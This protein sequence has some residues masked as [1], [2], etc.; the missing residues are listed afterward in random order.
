MPPVELAVEL[1]QRLR[2]C[3]S[4]SCWKW[5]AIKGG[6]YKPVT[7]MKAIWSMPLSFA[8]GSLFKKYAAMFAA[9][10]GLA[11]LVNG[12]ANIWSIWEENRSYLARL[13]AE[14]ASAA[15]SRISQFIKD[16][17]PQLGWTTHF[18]WL[19]YGIEQHRLDGQRL[20]RQ[21]PAIT[22][23]TLLDPQGRE[24]LRLSRQ[25]EDRVG[26]NVDYSTQDSYQTAIAGKIYY[27][28]VYFQ[29]QTEPYVTLAMGGAR[30]EAG[31]SIAEVNLQYIWDVVNQIRVGV[32]GRAYVVGP[33][34]QLIAHPDISRVLRNTNV[35]SL[36]QVAAARGAGPGAPLSSMSALDLD[37]NPV[38]TTS[39]V[40]E[41]MQW[42]VF[43]EL[44]ESEANAPLYRALSRWLVLTL[45]G[46]ALALIPALLL[47]R[48]MVVPIRSLAAGAEQ[49]GAGSL[50]H[51]IA[52]KSGDELESLSEQFN[53]MARRLQSSYEDLER[54][55]DER[56]RRLQDAD[57]AK[58]RF[59]AVASHDL[60]QPL[61][62]LNLFAAQLETTTDLAERQALV[63]N[64]TSSIDSMNKLFNEL[65][66]I[67]RLD[68]GALTPRISAFP[69]ADILSEIETTF[70][71]AARE[72]GLRFRV[73]KSS[74][75]VESDPIL[76]GRI[77]LNLVSN[78]VRYTWTG[79]VVVGCRRTRTGLRIDVCD[80]GPGIPEDQ[81]GTI[82]GEFYRIQ[83]AGQ[84][85]GEGLGLGLAIV[86]R[87]C[88]L[89]GHALDLTSIEGKG[90]RFSLSAPI[91][92]ARER[93]VSDVLLP[94]NDVLR[95]KLVVVIDDAPLVREGTRGLL[96]SWGCRVVVAE[97]GAEAIA[98]LAGAEP[99]LIISDLHLPDG[100]TGVEAIA[101]LRLRPGFDVPA[102]LISG[103]ISA[104]QIGTVDRTPYPLLHK[105]L[106]PMAL[107]A[108][109]TAMLQPSQMRRRR[110]FSEVDSE[111]PSRTPS[112][113]ALPPFGC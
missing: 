14:Q 113:Q 1:G 59:L 73:V 82:F 2:P 72:K 103:D 78:A 36:P 105:P 35:S 97:S 9:V 6:V 8:Q 90:S 57:L 75:W 18:S 74:E 69:I 37:G 65:L 26:S 4:I 16:I 68:A 108:M 45:A 77:L 15:A 17:E 28:P 11:L 100:E 21:V 92:S 22:Q 41:P 13:Q 102:F 23:L 12:L 94:R 3:K 67:S 33:E 44:P 87:L 32:S 54:K 52:I 40:V 62:A 29:R 46:M 80:T 60:R 50:H 27:G 47:A 98:R 86:E 66:D 58:S 96:N 63:R 43:V 31:V 56:T 104:R 53:S 51:R 64:I 101:Q 89:L 84:H 39:A 55:V 71:M 83:P 93:R 42:L 91:A 5:S 20:M 7:T 49:I 81:K 30:R 99:D 24:Q 10:L 109:I 38:V 79:G 25:A 107:R 88:R 112:R 85:V 106:N 34:G 48:Q 110:A 95:G 111:D 19:G 76:L 70:S 61:Y